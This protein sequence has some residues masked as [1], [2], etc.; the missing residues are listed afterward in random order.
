MVGLCSPLSSRASP[1]PLTSTKMRRPRACRGW[2]EG[3]GWCARRSF[4]GFP[5]V[6]RL[7]SQGERRAH[8]DGTTDAGWV[9]PGDGDHGVGR[10]TVL[11]VA[12]CWW[13]GSGR[14]LIW[15]PGVGVA[16]SGRSGM[17]VGVVPVGG[18]MSMSG[19]LGAS[20][21]AQRLGWRVRGAGRRWPRC[22]GLV[23]TPC[24][25]ER[26][27]TSWSSMPS[28]RTRPQRLAGT[29]SPG[30]WLRTSWVAIVANLVVRRFNGG[31]GVLGGCL[32]LLLLAW[33]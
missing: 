6:R 1:S 4:V 32:L 23:M 18:A 33:M 27:R 20:W 16:G 10:W 26:S 29:G 21:R 19:S 3:G 8:V 17:T 11:V 24:S 25:P 2:G 7:D 14:G 31:V 5:A 30:G 15:W 22:R 28:G 12:R 9:V 13:C